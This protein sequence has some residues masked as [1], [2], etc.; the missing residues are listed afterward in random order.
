LLWYQKVWHEESCNNQTTCTKTFTVQES[1]AGTYEYQG[2]IRGRLVNG[3]DDEAKTNPAT[4][5][6]TVKSTSP[7]RVDVSNPQQEEVIQSGSNNLIRWAHTGS[8]PKFD[9]YRI[10]YR[11]EGD[12]STTTIGTEDNINAFYFYWIPSEILSDK[13]NCQVGVQAEDINDTVLGNPGLSGKFTIKTSIEQ[14]NCVD[15][16]NHGNPLEKLDIVF[17]ADN[18]SESEKNKFISDVN[19]HT[20]ELL[21][22]YPFSAYKDRINIHRVDMFHSLCSIPNPIY[23]IYPVIICDDNNVRELASLCPWNQIIVLENSNVG[24]GMV[25]NEYMCVSSSAYPRITVH[26]F[27]HSFGGLWDEYLYHD[28]SGNPAIGDVASSPNCDSD[29]ACSKWSNI[30]DAG[31]FKGCTYNNAY[32]SI[33]SGIMRDFQ[34]TSFGPVNEKHLI[35]LLNHYR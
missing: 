32:R 14:T 34:A 27:G 23:P 31:C 8:D 15:V 18:Y 10:G 12:L 25:Q 9:H 29:S 22:V 1:Q 21:S 16:I 26:E 5:T 7:I 20:Q 35:E 6:G 3:D 13:T 24:C 2:L 17:V 30:A 11:C 19:A 28:Q 33:D 4:V